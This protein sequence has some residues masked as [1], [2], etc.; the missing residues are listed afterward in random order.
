[1]SNV[2]AEGTNASRTVSSMNSVLVLTRLCSASAIAE[3]AW[4]MFAVSRIEAS[5]D[6]EYVAGSGVGVGVGMLSASD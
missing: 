5:V 1:M 3:M 2:E 4:P 6:R